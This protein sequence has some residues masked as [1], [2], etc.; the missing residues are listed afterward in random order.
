MFADFS[1]DIKFFGIK[2]TK[3][4]FAVECEGIVFPQNTQ[5]SAK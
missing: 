1:G 3:L 4:V 5:E 2:I